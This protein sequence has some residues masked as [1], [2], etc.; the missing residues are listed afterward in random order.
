MVAAEDNKTNRLV[1]SKMLK[2]LNIDLTFATNGVEAVAAYSAKRPD[3]I[4]MDI[5]MP[6]MDGKEATREIRRLE[7]SRNQPSVPICALTAHAMDGDG[8]DIMSAGLDYYLT[9]PLKKQA[10]IEMIGNHLPQGLAPIS[11]T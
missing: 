3:F 2:D 4:F 9:K 8:E 6:E 1:L 7:K 10:L 11:G 5:S